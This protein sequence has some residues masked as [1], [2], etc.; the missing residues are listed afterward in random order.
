MSLHGIASRLSQEYE[1][2]V[3]SIW[4]HLSSGC[5]LT[6]ILKTPIPHFSWMVG[7]DFDFE[8]L[9]GKLAAFAAA[10][11][12]FEVRTTGLGIF[13][14]PE[15]I[16]LYVAMIKDDPLTGFHRKLWDLALP[17]V[18]SPSAYY[19]P[20]GWVPHITLAHGDTDPESMGCAI[21]LLA[22]EDLH[23]T[24]PVTEISL[25]FQEEDRA[26]EYARYPFRLKD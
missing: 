22:R 7:E 15:D 20:S 25:V 23:W 18:G 24:F 2:R 17:D 14:G 16:I 11:P 13:T 10:H 4:A 12:P 9:S 21:R 5:G 19:Q 8:A 6:A 26:E 1:D 3:R